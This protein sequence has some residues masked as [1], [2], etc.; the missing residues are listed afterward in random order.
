MAGAGG[1]SQ[2]VVRVPAPGEYQDIEALARHQ[3]SLAL[4]SRLA[5]S[6]ARTSPSNWSRAANV[7]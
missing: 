7:I 6:I 4:D 2:F 3:V 5:R 1:A